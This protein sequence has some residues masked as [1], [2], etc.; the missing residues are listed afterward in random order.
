[1]KKNF[2]TQKRITRKVTAQSMVEF[3]LVLPILLMLIFGIIEFGRIFQAWLSVQN[4][5]RF[6]VRYAVTGEYD[7]TYCNAD[8]VNA[9]IA[10]TTNTS[11]TIY[12]DNGI[13][14]PI[15]NPEAF[16]AA[17]TYNSDP[18]DCKIPGTYT[19]VLKSHY[20]FN[21][22]SG[23]KQTLATTETIQNMTEELQDYARVRSIRDVARAD[24]FAISADPTV[25]AY[26]Q[27]GEKGYF[28][29]VVYSSRLLV[30]CKANSVDPCVDSADPGAG[31]YWE[32]KADYGEDPGGPGDRV[33]VGVDFNHPLI[34]PFL[35]SVWPYIH[36]TT[37]REGIVENFRTSK[38]VNVASSILITPPTATL[39]PSTTLTFTDTVTD[40]STAT[41]T[42]TATE[43]PSQTFT[44]SSTLTPSNTSTASNTPTATHTGTN[45]GTSTKTNTATNTPTVTPVPSCGSIT[46]SLG[47]VPDRTDRLRAVITNN[48]VASIGFGSVTVYWP[49]Q[50]AAENLWRMFINGSRFYNTA[51]YT[52]PTSAS[53]NTTLPGGGT[54]SNL[55]IYF[56]GL[57]SRGLDGTFVVDVTV[58]ANGVS[59][60]LTASYTRKAPTATST[61]APTRTF[62]PS[63]TFTASNT[64]TPSN[65]S[66]NTS[67]STK[68]LTPSDTPTFTKTF[69]PSYTFTPSNTPTRTHTFTFTGT[70]TS[71]NTFTSSPT[72]TSTFTA[73]KTF[74][75]TPTFTPSDTPTRLPSPTQTSTPTYTFTPSSTN[76]KT[77][78]VDC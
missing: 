7:T 73:T 35:M 61:R 55:D 54:A 41:S 52:P 60:P 33:A 31:K 59:C 32:V 3:A 42:N 34:T 4:S 67:T 2:F 16:T 78:C 74:T 44:P 47:L 66:T 50:F 26:S 68:T 62:T 14:I 28:R 29:V 8:N 70:F 51:D 23:N 36:L 6:A 53:T 43:T 65:T 56:R 22:Y 46:M 39:T 15:S 12:T 72:K 48:N 64:F 71:T 38:V 40:T 21:T 1:M 58:T 27:T 37:V 30:Y 17:D 63:H 19:E 18:A 45:T 25:N 13:D 11:F 77:F 76:T 75:P 9:A 49:S 5:A 20:P 69:T 57:D 24:A 10:S